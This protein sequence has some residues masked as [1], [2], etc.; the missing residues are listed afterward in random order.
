[1]RILPEN[2]EIWSLWTYIQTQWRVSFG[3]LVGLDYNAVFQ[4][5]D[6]FNFRWTPRLWNGLQM[7]EA[8]TLKLQQE[9]QDNDQNNA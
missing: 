5:V 2:I 6:R 7:L 9:K 4:V 1:V 8:E 3:G